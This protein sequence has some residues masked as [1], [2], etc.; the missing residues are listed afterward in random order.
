MSTHDNLIL[1]FNQPIEIYT[2]GIKILRYLS[3][4]DSLLFTSTVIPGS[5]GMIDVLKIYQ[6]IFNSTVLQLQPNSFYQ[7]RNNVLFLIV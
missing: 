1:S 6:L 2:G 3:N 5:A 7:V 4:N